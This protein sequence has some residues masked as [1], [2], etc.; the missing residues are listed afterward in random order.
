MVTKIYLKT[1]K[2]EQHYELT[3][4]T[5]TNIANNQFREILV[6]FSCTDFI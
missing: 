3:A 6:L 2:M 4:N 1:N 5:K